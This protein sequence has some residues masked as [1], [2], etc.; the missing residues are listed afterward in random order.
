MTKENVQSRLKEFI[1]KIQAGD[2]DQGKYNIQ[3]SAGAYW[4]PINK[5]NVGEGTLSLSS[6]SLPAMDSL[7]DTDSHWPENFLPRPGPP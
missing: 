3:L 4:H 5:E 1:E 7:I 2:C 6:V